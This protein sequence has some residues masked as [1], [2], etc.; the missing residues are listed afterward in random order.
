LLLCSSVTK[1]ALAPVV[2]FSLSLDDTH[3]LEL[4][5]PSALMSPGGGVLP[6]LSSVP[7]SGIGAVA[8][9]PTGAASSSLLGLGVGS[10][11]GV[12]N[13]LSVYTI[14][15]ASWT[16]PNPSPYITPTLSPNRPATV[17]TPEIFHLLQTQQKI[18]ADPNFRE[19]VEKTGKMQVSSDINPHMGTEEIEFD[20]YDAIF[21]DEDS[22]DEEGDR[23]SRGRSR[24]PVV[25]SGG[26]GSAKSRQQAHSA[27]PPLSKS[28]KAGGRDAK[29]DSSEVDEAKRSRS[30]SV[31][32]RNSRRSRSSKRLNSIANGSNPMS[33]MALAPKKPSSPRAG[34][35]GVSMR[36][37]APRGSKASSKGF[38]GRSTAS[39]SEVSADEDEEDFD[40][41]V[42]IYV[43]TPPEVSK[44]IRSAKGH[45]YGVWLSDAHPLSLHSNQQC[46]F[47]H[48]VKEGSNY[49]NT[50]AAAAAR[51]ALEAVSDAAAIP[52][53][54]PAGAVVAA[55]PAAPVHVN[56]KR[57]EWQMDLMREFDHKR[58]LKFEAML[59]SQRQLSANASL[60]H[61]PPGNQFYN[62]IGKLSFAF[63]DYIYSCCCSC[64]LRSLLVC[65]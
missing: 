37:N 2:P 64:V 12:M 34:G 38:K 50:S 40:E 18:I 22:G 7:V 57:F 9:S 63:I 49:T 28:G 31:G 51:L 41:I 52:G 55:P 16:D 32:G 36:S 11:S 27:G 47:L 45:V 13:T 61:A 46:N 42:Q 39:P 4:S 43:E 30:T 62:H 60:Y 19:V 14:Q 15:A 6:Q 21:Q 26:P 44:L 29:P 23:G 54:P 58:L 48:F 59:I 10:P 20:F 24:S 33:C 35:K 8:T 3:Y 17:L 65:S 53:A 25:P 5:G 56:S 1:S